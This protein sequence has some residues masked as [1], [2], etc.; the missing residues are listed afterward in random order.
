MFANNLTIKYK[1]LKIYAYLRALVNYVKYA[2]TVY[3]R[4]S[5]QCIKQ[6][7]IVKW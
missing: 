3:S 6:Y 7:S 5:C 1:I 2:V 4:N